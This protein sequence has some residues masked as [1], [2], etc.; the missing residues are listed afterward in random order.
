SRARSGS[1]PPVRNRTRR[2][3]WT[4]PQPRVPESPLWWYGPARSVPPVRCRGFLDAVGA[5][6]YATVVLANSDRSHIG[7]RRA[8][9]AMKPNEKHAARHRGGAIGSTPLGP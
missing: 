1:T 9:G 6:L 3:R 5:G 4:T 2:C 7:R 8:R